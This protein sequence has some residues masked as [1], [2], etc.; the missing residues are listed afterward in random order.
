MNTS[1][2]LYAM[3]SLQMRSAYDAIILGTEKS[4]LN[5]EGLYTAMR[6]QRDTLMV[7]VFCTLVRGETIGGSILSLLLSCIKYYVN[8]CR[9]C[10][11][12]Q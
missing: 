8:F 12:G 10:E 6:H 7:S 2:V 1:I 4:V 9:K 3:C 11:C 5:P